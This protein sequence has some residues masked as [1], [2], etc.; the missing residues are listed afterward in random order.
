MKPSQEAQTKN[1]GYQNMGTDMRDNTFSESK[2]KTQQ[3]YGKI[4]ML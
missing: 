1:T 2:T 4:N 3:A